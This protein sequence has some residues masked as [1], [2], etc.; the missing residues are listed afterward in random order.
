[1]SIYTFNTVLL[2]AAKT[3]SPNLIGTS[4]SA[5]GVT[6]LSGNSENPVSLTT[7]RVGIVS[8]SSSDVG[9]AFN[10]IELSVGTTIHTASSFSINNYPTFTTNVLGSVF[11]IPRV[12]H[13]TTMAQVNTD[14]SYSVFTALS[15]VATVPIS[16]FSETFA[17]STPDTRRKYLL[18]YI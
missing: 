10:S 1:M 8:L 13:N 18:G 12:L 14:G 9:L 17:V 3:G 11:N 4:L 6:F 16:A 5:T 15:S 2:S 7:Q